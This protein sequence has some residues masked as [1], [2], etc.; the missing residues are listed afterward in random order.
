MC[1]TLFENSYL[2][3]HPW[4]LQQIDVDV[5]HYLLNGFDSI[6]FANGIYLSLFYHRCIPSYLIE[7]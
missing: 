5:D 3:P 4:P 1:L 2:H 6:L 7:Y